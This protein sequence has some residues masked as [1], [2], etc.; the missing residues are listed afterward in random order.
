MVHILLLLVICFFFAI[1]ESS[2]DDMLIKEEVR[3]ESTKNGN[4]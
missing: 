2:W 1:V 4:H 3:D